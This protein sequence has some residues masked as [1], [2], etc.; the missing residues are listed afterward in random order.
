MEGSIAVGRSQRKRLLEVYRR[1]ADPEVRRRAQIVLLLA[2]GW[3]WTV[4]AAVM[5]C[6]SRT[7][8]RWKDRFGAEGV[9]GLTGHP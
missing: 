4:I 1:D 7:I 6:S 5:F 2:D 8:A 9:E 3:T